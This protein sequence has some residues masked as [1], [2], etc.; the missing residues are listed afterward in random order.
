MRLLR[1]GI[2]G[3]QIAKPTGHPLPTVYGVLRRLKDR[4]SVGNRSL[5]WEPS[6]I[7]RKS[8]KK[9]PLT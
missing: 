8:K 3:S 6:W 5:H 7:C 2:K 1:A 9:T 4:D